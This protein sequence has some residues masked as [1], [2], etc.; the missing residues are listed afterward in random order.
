MAASAGLAGVASAACGVVT[1][2]EAVQA[3]RKSAAAAKHK[4]PLHRP[5]ARQRL[6]PSSQSPNFADPTGP[7]FTALSSHL[8]KSP[9]RWRKS[10][11]ASHFLQVISCKSFPSRPV[12]HI[13]PARDCRSAGL[14]A[15]IRDLDLLPTR[16]LQ[17]RAAFRIAFGA[18]TRLDPAANPDAVPGERLHIETRSR[19]TTRISLRYRNRKVVRPP[20]PEIQVD[21]GPAFVHG[22]HLAL[23]QSEPAS[24]RQHILRG[25]CVEHV[26]IRIGP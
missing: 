6:S 11:P 1:G 7:R 5:S 22:R 25:M 23:D 15:A 2:G 17:Q 26:I 4:C 10:F 9:A 8:R 3:A 13:I 20:W 19:K 16:R 14:L 18:T 24:L 21:R 12:L